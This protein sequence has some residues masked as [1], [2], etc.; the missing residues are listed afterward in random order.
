MVAEDVTAGRFNVALC[1]RPQVTVH[2]LAVHSGHMMH[3]WRINRIKLD[4]MIERIGL[5]WINHTNSKEN[6]DSLTFQETLLTLIP[7]FWGGGAWNGNSSFSESFYFSKTKW[8]IITLDNYK[9]TIIKLVLNIKVSMKIYTRLKN[10]KKSIKLACYEM[11]RKF[12][13]F[14]N[15]LIYL[16][17]FLVYLNYLVLI[18]MIALRK[19]EPSLEVLQYQINSWQN[20]SKLRTP[21]D[22]Q[23][24]V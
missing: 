19:G 13:Q 6:E 5:S 24:S 11:L 20:R 18:R 22:F 17:L 14:R 23:K 7:T 8:T 12:I 4:F 16:K 9:V 3:N 10:E 21:A 15:E 1:A 2:L